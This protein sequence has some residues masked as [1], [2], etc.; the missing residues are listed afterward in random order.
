MAHTHHPN[1]RLRPV[2][3]R[4]Q[5]LQH[6]DARSRIRARPEQDAAGYFPYF[7]RS[8]LRRFAIYQRHARRPFQPQAH[9]GPGPASVRHR[10]YHHRLHS[11]CQQFLQRAGRLGQGHDRLRVHTWIPVAYQ[12]IPA[13][14]GLS[15]LLKPYG[16]LDQA[17]GTCHQT[18]HLECV[19]LNRRR[20]SGAHDRRNS[21]PGSGA[22]GL[23]QCW[24]SSVQP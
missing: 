17:L 12:R 21:R 6:R 19:A 4:A 5:E 7:E 22:S 13:G 2:L 16:P 20:S 8:Y 3:L 1:D 9:D 23:R 18:V 11:R 15:S 24:P 10:Q 14:H